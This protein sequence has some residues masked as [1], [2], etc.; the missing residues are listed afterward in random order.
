[1]ADYANLN[2]SG[3][4]PSETYQYLMLRSGSVVT[5]GSGNLITGSLPISTSYAVSSSYE[6]ITEESSSHA[7]SASYSTFALSST[8]ASY[9]SAG[10]SVDTASWADSSLS[11]SYTSGS[12]IVAESYKLASKYYNTH[13]TTA[14][15]TL[16][17]ADNGRMV[18][19]STAS[20]VEVSSSLPTSF[21]C[22][23]YQ[24]GSGTEGQIV[25]LGESS[26]AVVNRS[27]QSASAGQ[28]ALMSIVRVGS[29]EEFILAGD[30][31]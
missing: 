16:S 11:S 27:A 5:D 26:L 10:A 8:S 31:A 7:D 24:S 28:Y 22:T 2:L 4:R 13:T 6:I 25:V 1:M 21:N 19:F 3:K 17:S 12:E 23:L 30:T 18:V 29:L 15:Y 9:A 20:T 14:S